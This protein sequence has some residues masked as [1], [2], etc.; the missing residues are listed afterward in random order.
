ML[1]R[2]SSSISFSSS[3]TKTEDGG[4]VLT[5]GYKSVGDLGTVEKSP[6]IITAKNHELSM[7][8]DTT[9]GYIYGHSCALFGCT[10][11]GYGCKTCY[12]NNMIDTKWD[13]QTGQDLSTFD[14]VE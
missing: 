8:F 1:K 12:S 3:G 11:G 14:Q 9:G 5:V 13:R 10:T 7:S 6:N 2:L 4:G